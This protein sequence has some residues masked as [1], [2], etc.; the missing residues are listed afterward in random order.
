MSLLS[1]FL[2]LNLA[3]K[4]WMFLMWL[5]MDLTNKLPPVITWIVYLFPMVAI[6]KYHKPGGFISINL[7][8]CISEVQKPGIKGSN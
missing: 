8:S 4:Q 5:L 2:I 6:I 3:G 1:V 7:F